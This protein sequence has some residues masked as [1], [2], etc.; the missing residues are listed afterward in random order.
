MDLK[1]KKPFVFWL[2]FFYNSVNTKS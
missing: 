1:E 2:A